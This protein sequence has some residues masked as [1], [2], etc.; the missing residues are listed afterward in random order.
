MAASERDLKS[1]RL[2]LRISARQR[3]LI[4]DAAEA[5]EMDVTTFVLDAVT[6]NAQRVLADRRMFSLPAERWDRWIEILDRPVTPLSA[7]PRLEKLL[8][9]P[10]VLEV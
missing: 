4:C 5:R 2:S 8:Q 10:S 6:S 7:K 3:R 9:T 1:E